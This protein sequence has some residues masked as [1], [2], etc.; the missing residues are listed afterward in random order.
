[1]RVVLPTAFILLALLLSLVGLLAYTASD[2]RTLGA[3][4]TGATTHPSGIGTPT[5]PRNATPSHPLSPLTVA[6]NRLVDQAGHAITLL[7]TVR[8]RSAS[9]CDLV[10]DDSPMTVADFQALKTWHSNSI[11]IQVSSWL[12]VQNP[13]C[14]WAVPGAPSAPSSYQQNIYQLVANAEVAGLYVILSLTT[15]EPFPTAVPV[16]ELTSGGGQYPLPSKADAVPFWTDLAHHYAT[17]GQI[18]FNAFSE[19]WPLTDTTPRQPD[20]ALW[21]WGGTVKVTPAMAKEQHITAGT[22][23]GWGMTGIVNLIRTYAPHNLILIDGP[24]KAGDLSQIR[25][26]PPNIYQDGTKT[27]TWGNIA[28]GVHVYCFPAT[29]AGCT[30]ASWDL[31]FGRET[32]QAPVVALE[33][34]EAGGTN[35][36]LGQTLLPYFTRH[37]MGMFAYAWC[38]CDNL[39]PFNWGML[40]SLD[41]TPSSYGQP[42]HDYFVAHYPA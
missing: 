6:G 17:D 35:H 41:G 5:A 13:T 15:V 10:P 34:G 11:E 37:G 7:G 29:G 18:I 23:S 31:A 26:H 4:D 33:F 14:W 38:R 21:Q 27:T 8:V 9:S 25:A 32:T 12:W 22:Y 42:L 16:D 2:P 36:V 3:G 20:W 28:F 39:P 40:A 19:P 1:M 30:P 24:S